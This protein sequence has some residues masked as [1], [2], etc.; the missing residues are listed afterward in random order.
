L[1]IALV[2][3]TLGLILY[4]AQLGNGRLVTPWYMPGLTTLGIVLLAVA[5]QQARSLWRWLALLLLLLLGSAEWAFVLATR[6]PAYAGPAAVGKPLPE[7]VTATADGTP[8]TQR[9]LK[10]DQHHVLVF[11]R[12]RW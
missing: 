9:D 12:G 3:P 2:L 10:G 6:L 8:F 11:F 4:A 7:F 1:L 5:L